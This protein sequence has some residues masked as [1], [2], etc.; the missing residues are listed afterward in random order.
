MD[1]ISE[2]VSPDQGMID[3]ETAGYRSKRIRV[4]GAY[5]LGGDIELTGCPEDIGTAA[6]FV[7]GGHGQT[8][9]GLIYRHLQALR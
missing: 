5:S 4:P 7:L 9:S 3:V 8:N 2:S 6:Y 1:I